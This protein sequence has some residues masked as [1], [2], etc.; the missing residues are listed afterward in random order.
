MAKV[1]FNEEMCKGCRLCTTV[2]PRKIVV[3]KEDVFNSKGFHPAEVT[4]MEKCTGCSSCAIIC[5]DC[6]I[7]VQK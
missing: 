5:P 4:E 1:I 6:V 3:M 2:C 7:E